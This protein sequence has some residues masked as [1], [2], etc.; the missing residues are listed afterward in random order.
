M[1]LANR[2][3][4][5]WARVPLAVVE[6]G[7]DHV[8]PWPFDQFCQ[9]MDDHL[10]RQGGPLSGAIVLSPSRIEAGVGY[11]LLVLGKDCHDLRARIQ[12][13]AEAFAKRAVSPGPGGSKPA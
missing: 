11:E 6:R 9:D 5:D 13:L 8:P 12:A 2:L 1:T 3:I 7:E 4:G 10:F